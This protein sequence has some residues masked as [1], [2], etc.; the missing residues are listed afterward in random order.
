M[1]FRRSIRFFKEHF[2]GE[3]IAIKNVDRNGPE[4]VVVTQTTNDRLLLI[5]YEK[6]AY[7]LINFKIDRLTD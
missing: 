1:Q 2:K 3:E 4:R 6:Y 5:D 7:R